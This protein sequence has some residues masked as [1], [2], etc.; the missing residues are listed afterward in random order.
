[1]IHRRGGQSGGDVDVPVEGVIRARW[2]TELRPD[3]LG[4]TPSNDDVFTDQRMVMIREHKDYMIAVTDG[5]GHRRL[6]AESDPAGR[7]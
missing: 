4:I 5:A 7:E 6:G 1:M 2:P 3:S